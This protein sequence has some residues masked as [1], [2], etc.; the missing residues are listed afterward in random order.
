MGQFFGVKR[1][2]WGLAIMALAAAALL[3]VRVDD[4]SRDWTT[5]QAATDSASA[6]PL[7]RPILAQATL[8]ELSQTLREFADQH[9][10]WKF[11]AEDLSS[12]Q[13]CFRLERTTRWFRFTDDVEVRATAVVSGGAGP[14]E[15][16][17]L[18]IQMH[19]QSRVGKGDLGQNPR[20]LRELGSY[21]RAELPL[22]DDEALRSPNQRPN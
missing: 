1:V 13:G 10:H 15:I 11:A 6:D 3:A 18:E 17:P 16:G 20:N 21:L 8:H 9:S 19:S 12:E 4:W 7:L 14:L 22:R 2:G 5:N